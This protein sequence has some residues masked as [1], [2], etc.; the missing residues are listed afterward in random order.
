MGLERLSLKGRFQRVRR[1]LRRHIEWL[2]VYLDLDRSISH[3]LWQ[4]LGV[5][6]RFDRAGESKRVL[7]IT[8]LLNV[9]T[10]LARSRGQEDTGDSGSFIRGM[11]MAEDGS[12][13]LVGYTYGAWDGVNAGETDLAALRL[14]TNGTEIWRYQVSCF[15]T[16]SPFTVLARR[17]YTYPISPREVWTVCLLN[18]QQALPFCASSSV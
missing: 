6:Y 15:R 11:T 2:F 1:G 17:A 8:N 16:V 12:M 14:D 9:E 10:V 18:S 5:D 4:C 3:G 13:V 7:N